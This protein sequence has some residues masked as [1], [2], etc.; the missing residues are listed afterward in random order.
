MFPPELHPLPAQNLV[1]Q[2][3][4]P[5]VTNTRP[6]LTVPLPRSPARTKR[7]LTP[8]LMLWINTYYGLNVDSRAWLSDQYLEG[9]CF[10]PRGAKCRGPRQALGHVY[11][12][13]MKTRTNIEVENNHVE[14]IMARYGVRT[15]TEAVDLALR[16]LA[17]QPMTLQEALE[18]RGA[19]AIAEVPEDYG[20]GPGR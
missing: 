17:G 5:N 16:H 1:L 4:T 14:A 7:S 3:A 18:M 10:H 20:P 6:P 19:Q 9:P 2:P 8:S 15:K 13:C 12:M 11:N